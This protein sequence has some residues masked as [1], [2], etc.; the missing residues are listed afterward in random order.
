MHAP[1][2]NSPKPTDDGARSVTDVLT[3]IWTAIE[4]IR[5][6]LAGRH[7]P[8]FTVDE[9][10]T[11]VGRSSYTVRKWVK[12]K[13][14]QATRINGT[15]PRGKLLIA[16]AELDKLIATGLGAN[17]PDAVVGID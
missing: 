5:S 2:D 8:Y 6:Q 11:T 13:K 4:D 10:A 14:I 9:V 7:K 3:R 17:I 12:E 15:G 1:S 16:R